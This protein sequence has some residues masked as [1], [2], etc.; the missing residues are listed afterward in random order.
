MKE[1]KDQRKLHYMTKLMKGFCRTANSCEAGL[2]V[3]HAEEAQREGDDLAQTGENF[4][5][6]DG[7]L[8]SI[9]EE[10]RF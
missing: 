3:I 1:T 9:G 5:V 7:K 10:I 8:K 4:R 6:A 2:I